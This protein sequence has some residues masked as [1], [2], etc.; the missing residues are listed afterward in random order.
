MCL[1]ISS[2]SLGGT[3]LRS[4]LGQ[5]C[6]DVLIHPHGYPG[7]LG[8]TREGAQKGIGLGK[9]V[10]TDGSDG[11]RKKGVGRGKGYVPGKDRAGG[12][13]GGINGQEDHGRVQLT[14]TCFG[15]QLIGGL[16]L[17]LLGI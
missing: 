9:R 12:I 8:K 11:V 16:H 13:R 6:L 15:P 5:I 1:R 17:F 3:V 2:V 4:F 7:H 10:K 14:L